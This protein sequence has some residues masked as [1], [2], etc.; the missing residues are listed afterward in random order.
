MAKVVWKP[1]EV[2]ALPPKRW[3]LRN[4]LGEGD[5]CT[6]YGDSG[7]GK[8]Y[9]ALTIAGILAAGA[10]WHDT[11][12]AT[13][14]YNVAYLPTEGTIDDVKERLATVEANGWDVEE[15]LS[16]LEIAPLSLH[17]VRSPSIRDDLLPFILENRI[18]VLFIDSLYS[19]L[20]GG[21][22]KDETLQ[23]YMATLKV[24]QMEQK[25]DDLAPLSIIQVHH[26][27]RAKFDQQKGQKINEGADSFH[28][29]GLI[30]NMSSYM[31]QY[32][33]ETKGKN[34]PKFKVTKGRSRFSSDYG[35]Y[36]VLDTETGLL[37]PSDVGKETKE[38]AFR[39]WSALKGEFLRS[40][41]IAAF[42]LDRSVTPSMIDEWI[43]KLKTNESVEQ[44]SQGRFKWIQGKS[45][46]DPR[47]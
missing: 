31:W 27:H 17:K 10:N 15:T 37:T 1:S 30:K 8:S 32:E 25:D 46:P 9:F 4:M 44:L 29:S 6:L 38:E 33:G 34:S 36:V 23:D 42:K 20:Q 40:D 5:I 41:A 22:T 3:M 28:G 13:R 12:V 2:L 21:L 45:T 39:K 19:S 11:I 7:I 14:P 47:I 16:I 35:F 26:N 18:E 43:G 24:L